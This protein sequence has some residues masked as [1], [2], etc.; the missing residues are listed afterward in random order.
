MGLW[1]EGEYYKKSRDSGPWVPPSIPSERYRNN[2]D[3]I[4]WD[5]NEPDPTNFNKEG[6]DEG[7]SRNAEGG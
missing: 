7:R 5:T 2:Y 1:I 4:Q 6:E 3:Q